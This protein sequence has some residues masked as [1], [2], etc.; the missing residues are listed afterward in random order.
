MTEMNKAAEAAAAH[1]V[2]SLSPHLVCRD[3]RKAIDFYKT[4][5]GATELMVLPGPD[6]KIM[7]ACLSINGS[8]VML[9]D[10]MI[11]CGAT[12]PQHL[13]G[14]PVT[15]HLIVDNAEAA[16]QRAVAAG[17]QLVM[18]VAEQ[19]W[20]DRYGIVEDPFGHRWSLST[21]GENAPRTAEELQAAAEAAFANANEGD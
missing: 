10:E 9:V 7:H 13:G 6:G 20:G 19:F 11:G 4:A 14:T 17:A 3:A 12:S 5:L 2:H 21:P 15:L 1:G 18:P 16:A 8:S